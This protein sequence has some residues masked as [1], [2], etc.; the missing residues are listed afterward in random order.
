MDVV[1]GAAV[2]LA[3]VAG[4]VAYARRAQAR[5]EAWVQREQ[6]RAHD[7]VAAQKRALLVRLQA[8][9]ADKEALL[10]AARAT[11]FLLE[12]VHSRQT[13]WHAEQTRQA[14]MGASVAELE[15]IVGKAGRAANEMAFG[16]S[17]VAKSLAELSQICEQTAQAMQAI[18][19]SVL[20]VQASA[21][22]TSLLSREVHQDAETGAEALRQTLAGIEKI[23][24]NNLT[25]EGIIV[26]LGQ[27]M[28]AVGT[29]LS[30]I[31]DVAEQ[32]H[33]LALNAAIIAAQAGEQGRGFAVVADEIK[34]LAERTGA[35]TKEIAQI[36]ADIQ[37]QSRRASSSMAEGVGAVHEGVRLGSNAG[38]ALGNIV[39]SAR[40]STQQADAIA[41]ETLGQGESSSQ[42]T[43]AIGHIAQ[44][45]QQIA[46]ATAEHAAGT[47]HISQS[48]K[49]AG[50]LVASLRAGPGRAEGGEPWR[51]WFAELP[52]QLQPLQKLLVEQAE[53]QERLAG[54][55]ERALQ[56]EDA[57]PGSLA[58]TASAAAHYRS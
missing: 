13:Q 52:A 12:G 45:V 40:R 7:E 1:L 46:Y 11:D 8:G 55:A 3:A 33:L 39:A 17:E 41:Q 43:G 32:T 36:L 23:R 14:G 56:A 38:L 4:A 48:T 10:Q 53:S 22:E 50:R 19:R 24:T 35:S 5:A 42:V 25:A 21:N 27:Q 20:S 44:M 6:R 31:D 57:A 16:S 51:A 9:R 47:E 30:V 2:V 34:A 26:E 28:S 15:E 49:E 54:D 37:T 18:D 58:P 29:I